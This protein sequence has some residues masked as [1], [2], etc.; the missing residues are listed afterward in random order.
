MTSNSHHV[1][2]I[3]PT[4]AADFNN[5]RSLCESMDRFV[6]F[7][8][9]HILVVPASDMRLFQPLAGRVREIISKEA[10]LHQH[11]FHKLP[12]PQRIRLP[13][14]GVR[15]I[16]EQWW[17]RGAGRLSGWL[18]Q[19]IIKLSAPEITEDEHVLFVDSDVALVR[20]LKLERLIAGDAVRLHEHT[21]GASLETHQRWRRAALELIGTNSD[22]V[23][24]KNYI[25]HLIGWRRSVIVR[26]QQRIEAVTGMDWRLA[27][28]RRKDIS[29]Y[30]IYGYFVQ[31]EGEAKSGHTMA[32]LDLVRSLWVSDADAVA[33][34]RGT[35]S[36]SEVAVH[37][38]SVL[39]MSDV[40]RAGWIAAM[41]DDTL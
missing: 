39:A 41:S 6:T 37:I 22:E 5:A 25:G 28:S 13:L 3:T 36:P 19:Q 7:P 12:V 23:P 30:I 1:T 38:Q 8:S 21:E 34:F 10:V 31:Q 20:P 32:S 27:L 9:R 29:E 24:V 16:K 11:G 35:L 15:R 18:I 33:R 4:Y 40:E 26:L 14:L 17:L 2:I